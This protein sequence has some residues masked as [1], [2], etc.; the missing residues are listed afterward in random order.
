MDTVVTMGSERYVVKEVLFKPATSTDKVYEGY[1]VCYNYDETTDFEGNSA[2]V[3]NYS[4]SAT[5]FAE[6]SQ[7][8]TAR[9]T[10]VEKPSGKNVDFFAGVVHKD[11]NGAG[12]GDIIKII[13][14]TKGTVVP[15]Y[16]DV[17]CTN[18]STALAVMNGSYK[19][20]D[21]EYSGSTDRGRIIGVANETIDRSSTSGLTWMRFGG[22]FDIG[23]GVSTNFIVGDSEGAGSLTIIPCHLSCE[24]VQ[25]GG[26]LHTLRLRGE[27]AGAGGGSGASGGVGLRCEGV[28]NST[29]VT[30]TSAASTHLIFK[31]GAT[32]A[33][34]A[35]FEGLY[36]K[37][38][39][40][41]GTPAA[42][43]NA[44]VQA[45]RFVTQLDEDPGTHAMLRFETEG[46]DTPDYWFTAKT[47]E[48]VVLAAES[49][50]AV[51]HTIKV[52]IEGTDYYIMVSDTA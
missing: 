28:V 48:A 21:P 3:N 12:D 29:A 32:N 26:S 11:S 7:D 6:G 23:A 31:T 47:D 17:D 8:Y 9:F 15:V 45:A 25:A 37:V 43:A 22:P 50:A 24:S 1:L 4:R 39:N 14:P 49:S 10:R 33:A 13:V 38:E 51:S 2:T 40:Q 34:S 27:I 36:C 52:E 19:A 44:E 16:T 41:D 42:L 35:L 20:T 46:S 18:G 30:S 5:S